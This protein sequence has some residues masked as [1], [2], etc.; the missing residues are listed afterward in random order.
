MQVEMSLK[1]T[2][3]IPDETFDPKH[4]LLVEQPAIQYA[5]LTIYP[6]GRKMEV[7]ATGKDADGKPF[8]ITNKGQLD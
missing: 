7:V 8:Q 3:T 6:N 5:D 1:F 2:I 4:T